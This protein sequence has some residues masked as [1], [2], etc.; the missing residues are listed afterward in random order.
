M[1]Q[2]EL[3]ASRLSLWV[4]NLANT[5][6]L[7]DSKAN[8]GFVK[9]IQ[10]SI[11]WDEENTVI[12]VNRAQ[13]FLDS[14]SPWSFVFVRPFTCPLTIMTPGISQLNEL[15]LTT[16][17]LD[18]MERKDSVRMTLSNT[19]DKLRVASL[20]RTGEDCKMV[21]V[22]SEHLF[23]EGIL[24][25]DFFVIKI[26]SWKTCHMLGRMAALAANSTPVRTMKFCPGLFEKHCPDLTMGRRAECW[27][28]IDNWEPVINDHGRNDSVH[29]HGDKIGTGAV[30][31]LDEEPI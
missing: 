3:K 8:T 14:R 27:F 31:L 20:I 10:V 28:V 1:L 11:N 24:V 30:H 13:L 18:L 26:F 12:R 22:K 9:V 17:C 16:V 5:Q 19:I 29:E 6:V 4:M 2:L 23:K 25:L 7:C 21:L 15:V